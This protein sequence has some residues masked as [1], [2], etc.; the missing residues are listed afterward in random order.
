MTHSY[1]LLI[2]RRKKFAISWFKRE[3]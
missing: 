1:L 2:F 3:I